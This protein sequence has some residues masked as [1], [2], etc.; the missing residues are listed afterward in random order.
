MNKGMALLTLLGVLIGTLAGPA[1]MAATI[2]LEAYSFD[3]TQGEPVLA[4]RM[5]ASG[6]E[7]MDYGYYLVQ[8]DREIT[9]AWNDA[10]AAAGAEIYG[11]IAQ[12]AYL[13]RLD[14]GAH[15]RVASLDGTSALVPF[16]PAY[17]LDPGIGLSV[18]ASPE[19]LQDPN[20]LL[21]VRVFRNP[22]GVARALEGL[23]GQIADRV[24]NATARRLVV[25][26]PKDR[27]E[28]AARIHDVW[29]I[30]EK[31]EFRTQNNTTKWVVQSNSSGWTPIWDHGL[32][33]EGQLFT[34]MDSGVD[35]NACW[36]RETGNAAPGPSHRKIINYT[37]FG[38]NAYDG[39][40]TGH[41]SHVAGT[42]AGDQSYI[43]PGNYNYNGMAYKAKFTVQDVGA[44]DWSACNVGT[45]NVPSDL[46]TAFDAAYNLGARVHTNS[47]GSTSNAYDNYCVDVDDAMWRHKD[48]LV[49]FAAGNSGPNGSTVGS[50]GT[51]K[52]LVTVGATQ[53]APSQETMASYSSRGPASDSRFKPTVTAPGGE[54]PNYINSVDNDPGNPPAATC[55][56]ASSPFQG[57]SMATPAVSGC[58]LLVRDYYMRGFYPNGAASGDAL[59]PSAALM[60]ATL[61]SSTKDMSTADIPN[62]N[63]GWG[64]VLLDNALYF[65]GDTRELMAH[66]VAP[67]LQTGGSWSENFSVDSAA[68]RLVV[69]LVW[70]DYPGTSGSGVKLVNDLD[71]LV[72]APNGTQYKGNVFSGGQSAT[73]GNH[74]RLNVEECVR[75]NSPATGNWTVRVSGYNVPQGPQPFAVVL[76]GA[77]G[78]WPGGTESVEPVPGLA[79]E[80]SVTASPNP[81][82]G[83]T[84]IE[85]A[86]PSGHAGLVTVEIADVQG[87]VVRTLV[88]KG[89]SGGRYQAT[90]EGLDQTGNTVAQGVYFAR[91]SAGD[92]TASTK[93]IVQR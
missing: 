51:A 8:R 62:N 52:N 13:V 71:L 26:L 73:G 7:A 42:V 53:Q 15:A 23:G 65:D 50:P 35:Y 57:T 36:F 92:E 9:P 75:I 70:T 44:D 19:R 83:L 63:E 20:Y 14:R 56:V 41:G 22:D 6:Q 38:G 54:S 37:N 32:Y 59:T 2:S 40:D 87:R 30:E 16:H 61:V 46:T 80:L 49:V 39:C 74:D 91:V 77:F 85:Y 27:L 55:N 24:E 29:W 84:N 18:F 72:T 58:A 82:R 88:H 5:R 78:N 67:G 43:T 89:Q 31:P 64:R 47:W 68:E 1:A 11:Y 86:V 34:I 45:V 93:V 33:G 69:T 48:F 76:N 60:K 17:R 10:L 79:S 4:E 90:W 25:S 21:V 66:D 81:M 28:D 3:P 12:N